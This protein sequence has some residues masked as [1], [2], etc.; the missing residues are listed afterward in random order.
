MSAESLQAKPGWVLAG[1]CLLA[2]LASAVN[3]DFMLRLGVSVSHLTGDLSRISSEAVKSGSPWTP[4]LAVLCLSVLGFISGAATAGFFIHHP[5]VELSRPYGRS[6]VAV[7][8]LLVCAHLAAFH[9]MPAACFLAAW[10]CGMQNALATRYRGLVLR[11]THITG[12]LTDLGQLLGMRLRGHP[13]EPWKITTPLLLAVAFASGAFGGAWLNLKWQWP[14]TL[15]CGY[16][17]LFGGIGWSL[18]KRIRLAR[19]RAAAKVTPASGR[20]EPK[21]SDPR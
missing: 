13:L 6:V 12:L 10:A 4:Q 20:S 15:L 2:A 14:V 7:G 21:A 17:Y 8:A 18:L 19:Y 5:N 16:A 3:A 11:T 1:G 9:S